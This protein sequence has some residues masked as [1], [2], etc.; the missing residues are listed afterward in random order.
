V[1]TK[2]DWR[3]GVFDRKP[4]FV[5][6]YYMAP[7][8]WQIIKRDAAGRKRNGN[9]RSITLDEAP[10]AVIETAVK[11]ASL[12]GDGLYGV[13]LKQ[14]DD[15]VVVIEI[16]DNP[17]IDAGVEDAVLGPALYK[18]IMEGFVKRIEAIRRLGRR[19]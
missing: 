16:N 15:G 1:P 3:V 17:N 9:H 10:A 14:L 19:P 4:L 5:C 18:H 12:I 6:Q 7:Q 8:H 2:F 11:A 13:D